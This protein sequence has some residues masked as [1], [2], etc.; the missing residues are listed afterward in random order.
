MP[1]FFVRPA[2]Q[3]HAREPRGPPRV[4]SGG[5]R[6][7]GGCLE[8][9]RSDRLIVAVCADIVREEL[10]YPDEWWFD[11]EKKMLYYLPNS[12]ASSPVNESSFVGT[13]LAVL[14]NVSG[15]MASP[16]HHVALRGLTLRDTRETYMD[17]HGMPSGGD[18]AIQ[19]Q[20]VGGAVT[21]V[22][23]EAI[24]IEQCNFS[25][26]D[27]NGV[28]LGGYNLNASVLSSVFVSKTCA[29]G[30]RRGRRAG[31]PRFMRHF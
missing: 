31:L 27:G 23:T 20:Q 22:G 13:K 14:F 11:I 26:I 16:A 12:T 25:R 5:S 24:V 15:S 6:T 18:W 10:D 9:L 21:L 8:V 1:H 3:M 7:V 19:N 17:P 4:P 29:A 28:F 30:V 2:A